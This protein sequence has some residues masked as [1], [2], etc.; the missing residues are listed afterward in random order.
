MSKHYSS[1]IEYDFYDKG[2]DELETKATDFSEGNDNLKTAL[3]SLWNNNIKT[4]GCCTGHDDTESIPYL[5]ILVDGSNIYR[6]N[7]ILKFFLEYNDDINITFNQNQDNL[8]IA[9][10]YVGA[11]DEKKRDFMFKKIGDL[12]KIDNYDIADILKNIQL[13]AKVMKSNKL[14]MKYHIEQEST[15]LSISKPFSIYQYEEN[16]LPYLQDALDNLRTNS[17]INLGAYRCNEEDIEEMVSILYPN[18]KED[19]RKRGQV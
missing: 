5:N 3:L 8:S 14:T 2:N 1:K 15:V 10:Y 12:S 18:M 4:Q 19:T 6:I 16:E 11:H 13:L 17:Q 7:N 9:F